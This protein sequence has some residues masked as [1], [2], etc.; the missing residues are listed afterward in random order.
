[1][2]APDR[3][4]WQLP[5]SSNLTAGLG[6][7][8]AALL[9]TFEPPDPDVL[10]E[11]LLP[12]WL[13]LTR[14]LADSGPGRA[15]FL[16]DLQQRLK[17]LRGQVA[18]FSSA[19]VLRPHWL[20]RDVHVC[21]VGSSRQAV[22]HAKLWLL[23]R[24]PGPESQDSTLEIV[25]SSTNLTRA[26]LQNQI[27]AGWR[28]VVQLEKA[29]AHRLASWGVLPGFLAELGL[30]SGRNGR[31]TVRHWLNDV[32]PRAQCPDVAFVASVPGRHKGS[33]MHRA[34][35]AWGVAGL[36]HLRPIARTRR[37]EIVAPSV[38]SFSMDA[39]EQWADRAGT[40]ADR[41]ALVWIP[42][43]HQWGRQGWSMPSDTAVILR[44]SD[45]TVKAFPEKREAIEEFHEDWDRTRDRWFH[46]KLYWIR[47]AHRHRLLITSAN[48]SQAAWGEPLP[49]GGLV[50]ENFEFGVA[51]DCP[52]SPLEIVEL[53]DGDLEAQPPPPRVPASTIPW[54]EGSW[55]GKLIRIAARLSGAGARLLP[56]VEVVCSGKS[57]KKTLR[58]H[59]KGNKAFLAE[60]HWPPA[61]GIPVTVVIGTRGK[62]PEKVAVI[63][64]DIRP[65]SANS[66]EEFEGVDPEEAERLELRLLEERYGGPSADDPEPPEPDPDESMDGDTPPTEPP[67][68]GSAKPGQGWDPL[69]SGPPANYEVPAVVN[70]REKLAI[71]TNW[72]EK[73]AAISEDD[74]DDPLSIIEDG[75][76]LLALW[77]SQDHAE[78]GMAGLATRVAI[79]ELEARLERCR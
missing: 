37:I 21:H 38:G 32:L 4:E 40:S 63:I 57:Q 59:R 47:D 2:K 7:L 44:E 30:Q 28:A 35:S 16:V 50:I 46:G 77:R 3:P 33:T 45:V 26:A 43:G 39:L 69:V 5:S 25:V 11:D 17:A 55:D 24:G 18:I 67:D 64:S 53:L 72:A 54:S 9:T 65:R 12:G 49:G 27:Q 68:S 19:G 22:Q 29:A 66:Q 62:M 15:T 8:R 48:W 6:P 70:A 42:K 56:D 79:G 1:M 14:E 20:W 13:G 76:R 71:V 31:A 61:R 58:W 51:F 10:V 60:L 36:R 41:L 75:R 34:E 73:C 78:E 74:R 52:W 23:H